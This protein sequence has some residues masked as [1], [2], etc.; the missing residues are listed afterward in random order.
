MSSRAELVKGR[1]MK[2]FQDVPYAAMYPSH[3]AYLVAVLREAGASLEEDRVDMPDAIPHKL[4]LLSIF[5]SQ[6]KMY[7]CLN[8][9]KQPLAN[10]SAKCR[11]GMYKS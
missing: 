11:K 7:E 9:D 8:L 10:M 4:H 6:F 3:T 5:A 2:F 1:E